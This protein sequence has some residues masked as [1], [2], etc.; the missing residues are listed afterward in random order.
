MRPLTSAGACRRLQPGVITPLPS[1]RPLAMFSRQYDAA[2]G[3]QVRLVCIAVG[4]AGVQRAVGVARFELRI[5]P[6][7]KVLSSGECRKCPAK[8]WRRRFESAIVLAP[9]CGMAV[10]MVIGAE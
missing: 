10:L 8:Y 6:P 1:V 9:K 7:L 4:A 2:A 5:A 3:G